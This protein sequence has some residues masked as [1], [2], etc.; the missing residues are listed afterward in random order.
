MTV[1]RRDD[2]VVGRMMVCLLVGMSC[3]CVLFVCVCV[4]GLLWTL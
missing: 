1:V 3:V 4:C 2:I